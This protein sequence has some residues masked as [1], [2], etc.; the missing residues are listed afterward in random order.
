MSQ[1]LLQK[2]EK[3]LDVGEQSF[4]NDTVILLVIICLKRGPNLLLFRPVACYRLNR[5]KSCHR[6]ASRSANRRR[7]VSPQTKHLRTV[8][9]KATGT[10]CNVFRLLTRHSTLSQTSKLTLYK[11]LI[12]SL[13]TYDAPGSNTTCD[14]NYLKVQ[15]VQSKSL[16]VIGA[17]PRGTP[18]SHLH[19][20]LNIEPIRDFIH[21]LTAKFC[22]NCQSHPKSLVQQIGNYTP[23]DLNSLYKTCR[24][25][26]P[27][28]VVL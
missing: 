12:L 22:S 18:I 7:T 19:D 5:Q 1:N 28:H 20:T 21:K 15:F 14:S 4:L 6:P 3:C 24:H 16:R 10:L 25:K 17:C 9:N 26:R 8:T 23:L 11:L 2:C 27:K 13:L